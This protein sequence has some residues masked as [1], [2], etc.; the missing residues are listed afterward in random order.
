MT[1][2]VPE[3]YFRLLD[4]DRPEGTRVEASGS[5][6]GPWFADAQHMGPPSALLIRALERRSGREDVRLARVTVEV[7]GKVP[8][9]ELVVRAEVTRPGRTIEL[10]TAELAATDPASGTVRPVA[11]AHGWF[12]GVGDTADVVTVPGTAMPALPGPEDGAQRDIPDGWL[13]GYLTSVDWRWITGGLDVTGPGRAW[14]RL[15]GQVVEG[16]EPTPTQ[17]LAAVADSTNGA[18]SRLDLRRWLFVN[19]DLTL[20]LHRVPS[21]EW[22]GLDADSVIGPEGT[23]TAY[24]VLHDEHGPVGRAAQALTVR[25]R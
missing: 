2:P 7:L 8:V 14:G 21:G 16:E 23:G 13:P 18:A 12:H 11:R 22:T 9:D 17:R 1:A 3:P 20:H 24:S 25:P 6:A 15:R 4:D 19:T 5:T 10:V